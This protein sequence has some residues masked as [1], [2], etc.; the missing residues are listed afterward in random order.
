M[1]S[2]ARV[3]A[4]T[5]LLPELRLIPGFALDLTTTDTDGRA[6]DLDEKEMLEFGFTMDEVLGR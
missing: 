5:K 4:A 6:W 3:T 1:Y 2:P